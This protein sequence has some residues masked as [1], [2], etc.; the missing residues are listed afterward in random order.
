V[1]GR[2]KQGL[3]DEGIGEQEADDW[4]V[5]FTPLPDSL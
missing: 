4:A 3:M 2:W 5:C 1:Q